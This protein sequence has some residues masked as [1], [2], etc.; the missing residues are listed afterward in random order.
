MRAKQPRVQRLRGPRHFPKPVRRQVRLTSIYLIALL[1]SLAVNASGSLQLHAVSDKGSS[2]AGCGRNDWLSFT[3]AG[4]VDV[5]LEAYVLADDKGA[6]HEDAFTFAASTSIAARST[7]VLCQGGAGSF[8]FGIG[9]DDTITLFDTTGNIVDSTT[10]EG[11]G[12]FDNVWTRTQAGW[13]YVA[14]P[15]HAPTNDG[16]ADPVFFAAST[17]PSITVVLKQPDWDSLASCKSENYLVAK[18][19]RV[20]A[21]DYHSATCR[22]MYSTHDATMPCRVKRK[23]EASWKNMTDKPSLKVKLDQ[24][25]NGLKEL[26]L[27]NAVQDQSKIAERVGYKMYRMAG[28]LAPRANTARVSLHVAGDISR[29]T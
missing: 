6:S 16:F 21:C 25:W 20:Q 10:L 9:G 29:R 27:N 26:T 5:D 19:D 11:S 13:G 8:Q 28:V 24:T 3:N 14:G 23:G 12:A 2:T 4:S 22:V 18:T 1:S 17:V 15:L 7:M